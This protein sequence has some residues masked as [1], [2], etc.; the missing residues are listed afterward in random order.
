MTLKPSS[1]K[2]RL[3]FDTNIYI[4]ASSPTSFISRFVFGTKQGVNP[5]ALF[6]SPAILM[7]IQAK[8]ETK[9]GFPR[10][11]AATYIAAVAEEATLVHPIATIRAIVSDPD[12]NIILECAVQA[13]A[14]LIIS[15]DKHLLGL[16]TYEDIGIVHP[17]EL[18]RMF[19]DKIQPNAD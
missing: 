19:A 8:L 2:L 7:E 14:H 13:R 4:A 18:K 10:A 17:S 11:K 16:K 15:A 6:V 1:A 5:Y 9:I 12:D 3:V